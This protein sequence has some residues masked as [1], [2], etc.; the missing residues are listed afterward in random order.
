MDTIK[1]SRFRS[2]RRSERIPL[3]VPLFVSSL[4]PSTKFSERCETTSV[5]RHGCLLRS[6]KQLQVGV[7]VRLDIP[8]TDRTTSA[9]VVSASVA[10]RDSQTFEVALELDKAQNFWGIRFPPDD[11][12]EQKTQEAPAPPLEKAEAPPASQP[13]VAA[14]GKAAASPSPQAPQPA[15]PLAPATRE[16]TTPAP[17]SAPAAS[18]PTATPAGPAVDQFEPHLR[19]KAKAISAE[20]ENSYRQSLGDL[21]LRLRADFEQKAAADWEHYRNEAQQSLREVA[22][23]VRE[24]VNQELERRRQDT[25]DLEA[26]MKAAEDLRKEVVARLQ[27]AGEIF[28]QQVGQERDELLH[29]AREEL[30]TLASEV[31]AQIEQALQQHTSSTADFPKQF[32]EVRGNRDYIESLIRT[33]PQTVNQRVE[34]SV[35]AALERV[36]ARLQEEATDLRESQAEQLEQDLREAENGLRQKLFED[37][38]R[39]E[40]ES[41]D[42]IHVRVEEAKALESRLRQ[43]TEQAQS[44]SE[45]RF[46]QLLSE[47]QAQF[48][49]QL[50]E[51]RE[52]FTADVEQRGHQL[53]ERAENAVRTLGEQAWNSLKQQLQAG[54]DERYQE[55]RQTLESAQAETTRLETRAEKLAARLDADLESRLEQALTDVLGRA[56]DEFQ[57]V[58]EIVGETVRQN[59]LSALEDK[60]E[61]T[62]TPLVS[63]GEGAA[64]HLQRLLGSVK[65]DRAR[66]E[67]QLVEFQRQADQ[68]QAGL[69]QET[70]A[71]HK[72]LKDTVA[73]V[74]EHA[75]EQFKYTGEAVRQ[76]MLNSLKAENAHFEDRAAAFRRE[77]EQAQAWLT[78]ESQQFQKLVHDALV[79]ASG[80]IK[81]RIHQAVEM[82]DEPVERR[83]QEARAQLEAMAASKTEEL[84]RQLDEMHH[85]L[86]T[87]RTELENSVEESLRAR[88]SDVLGRLEQETEKLARDASRHLQTTLNEALDS[89]SR[90]LRDKLGPLS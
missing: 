59:V 57:Q 75:R 89:V 1:T 84:Q 64:S 43:Y 47:L 76:E 40:R 63:R 11:W 12:R 13:P 31:R 72:R 42:R 15:P 32:E 54:F 77:V 53:Y 19:E 73:D 10:E 90:M 41:L 37:F 74:M 80:Q 9:H 58:A 52:E 33:L 30:E 44:E 4:D 55:V 66:L 8:H 23:Q 86:A 21:L 87:R 70:Q 35:A 25:A 67:S 34:E 16:A 81:G 18:A 24:Q 78:Q 65:D 85:R 82:V 2:L 50:A 60:V 68:A 14:G 7:R 79:E 83:T 26:K 71:C 29:Q 45:D 20:F 38:D 56:R 17:L 27:T 28:H 46:R 48:S 22:L 3:A 5:S 69:A 51:R 88:V 36:R 62:V 49:D 39:Q 61:R 6:P